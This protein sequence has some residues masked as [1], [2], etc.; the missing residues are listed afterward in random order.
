[1]K[2]TSKEKPKPQAEENILEAR[3]IATNE[4]K[5]LIYKSYDAIREVLQ[6]SGVNW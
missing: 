5:P 1:M 2:G 4:L 3:W 6:Q